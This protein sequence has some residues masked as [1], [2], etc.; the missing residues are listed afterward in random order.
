MTR[1]TR[2][3]VL[4]AGLT[5]VG[6]GLAGCYRVSPVIGSGRRPSTPP[7]LAPERSRVAWLE[8][9]LARQQ[10]ALGQSGWAAA[11]QRHAE[12]LR[13]ADPLGGRNADSTPV[14]EASPVPTSATASPDRGHTGER[15]EGD[16]GGSALGRTTEQVCRQACLA[17]PDPSWVLLWA[18]LA[19]F[20][21]AQQ[22]VSAKTATI[23]P[24]TAS[25]VSPVDIGAQDLTAARQAL[26]SRY[27]ALVTGLEWG[28]GRLASGSTWHTWARDRLT[29][30]T[31]QRAGLRATLRASSASPVA[32]VPGYPMAATPSTAASAKELWSDL[33]L[34]VLGGLG[35]VTAASQ[36][37]DRVAGIEAMTAQVT[38][39]GQ[40][41]TGVP[42]WPGWV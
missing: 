1:A 26:L 36:P 22:A 24:P 4:A 40:L 31:A 37:D 19:T 12:V 42:V 27:N 32:A 14:I 10:A 3:T 7:S 9:E 8:T 18:S 25:Q 33:E 21:A 29:T 41:G 17:A 2:R 5:L 6:T 16:Q 39:L 23:P 20:A 28:L 38:V 34:G 30:V 11:H 35:R 13:Q 15:N